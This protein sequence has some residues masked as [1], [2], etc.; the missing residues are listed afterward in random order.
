MEPPR[1]EA[2]G[3]EESLA[4]PILGPVGSGGNGKGMHHVDAHC[5]MPGWWIAAVDGLELPGDAARAGC[6]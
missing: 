6:P 1:G 4:N 3:G 5:L 2:C